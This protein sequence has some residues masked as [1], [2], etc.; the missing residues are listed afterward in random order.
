MASVTIHV[1]SVT[2]L[3]PHQDI[4]CALAVF[5]AL[6]ASGSLSK[7][8][9]PRSHRLFLLLPSEECV[10]P[11]C[12]PQYLPTRTEERMFDG[13]APGGPSLAAV[14]IGKDR[15]RHRRHYSAALRLAP[16]SGSTVGPA[17]RRKLSVRHLSP[18]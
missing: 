6:A 3:R 2:L 1:A 18:D 15:A 9:S 11:S 7:L 16:H 10:E 17:G 5:R 13:R 14:E 12:S 4:A 8:P